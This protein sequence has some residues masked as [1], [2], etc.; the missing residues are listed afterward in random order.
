[1]QSYSEELYYEG[2]SEYTFYEYI[3]QSDGYLRQE[4]TIDF[5]QSYYYQ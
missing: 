1:M 4:T 2:K 5:P 3:A